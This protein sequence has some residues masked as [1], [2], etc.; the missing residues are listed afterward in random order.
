M[1]K[2][3]RTSPDCLHLTTFRFLSLLSLL[4]STPHVSAQWTWDKVYPSMP[5]TPGYQ[6]GYDTC[7]AK[8]SPSYTEYDPNPKQGEGTWTGDS[9]IHDP[10][11]LIHTKEGYLLVFGS[12]QGVC[13]SS[14]GIM[15]KVMDP[16]TNVWKAGP[17]L[18]GGCGAA[19][20]PKWIPVTD[21]DAPLMDFDAPEVLYSPTPVFPTPNYRFT[22]DPSELREW[23]MY[24]SVYIN[25]LDVTDDTQLYESA[26]GCIGRATATGPPDN[27][28]W[29]D[30][31]RPVYCS[32]ADYDD[33]GSP[34]QL[35]YATA[36][37]YVEAVD[38]G[39][40]IDPAVFLDEDGTYYMSWGS[41]VIHAVPLDPL[42]GHLTPQAH[43]RHCRGPCKD[44]PDYRK[45][46]AAAY[47][48]LSY[49]GVGE[50]NEAP[51]ILRK[52]V[53]GGSRSSSSP[54]RTYHYLF[55]NWW[56]CCA[57]KC[58]TYEIRIGRST[59]GVLGPYRDEKGHRMDRRSRQSFWG[60]S[61]HSGGSVFLQGDGRYVGPGHPD[62]FRYRKEKKEEEE[63]GSE[64]GASA[65]EES[66]EEEETL[67]FTF[68]WYDR[69][70]KG[71][72]AKLAAREL[73]F[74]D[75]TGWP[76]LSP[77]PWDVCLVTECTTT[78]CADD[79]NFQIG[80][81]KKRNCLWVRKKAG[82]RKREC[83]IRP[84]VQKACPVTCGY[85][86]EDDPVFVFK[87]G[88]KNKDCEWL[89][90]RT[91][92]KRSKFC[93]KKANVQSGCPVVC[94]SCQEYVSM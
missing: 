18:F 38:D 9:S 62:V 87:V 15:T 54:A 35:R 89:A 29:T 46:N 78:V 85:C 88:K 58:S 48:V 49:G 11:H 19:A 67:V 50:F 41:G 34:Y 13:G 42:T 72:T 8:Y 23:V 25:T 71:G 51:F 10:T 16:G 82:R 26:Q 77:K 75:E 94:D 47:T 1:T 17:Q 53:G 40:G 68:H 76:L 63:E 12:G 90:G 92:K 70:E 37:E 3:R 56:G 66:G 69:L 28:V 20:R 30:D 80:G 7:D 84:E 31:G 39:V 64:Y 32:N 57:G 91:K 27:L 24:Y 44:G 59:R 86:C 2:R 52:T 6:L 4:P 55:V 21:A 65:I 22:Q 5:D 60:E 79:Q 74:D 36:E 93:K 83:A 33:D 81:N 43:S 45:S 14:R 73:T 61:Q